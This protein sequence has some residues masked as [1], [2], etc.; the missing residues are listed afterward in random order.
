MFAVV[1]AQAASIRTRSPAAAEAALSVADLFCV[2]LPQVDA[3]ACK[4]VE[5]MRR[6]TGTP[7]A[8]RVAK[9][10]VAAALQR[11]SALRAK[12]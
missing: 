8:D 11:L 1:L 10:S 12:Q 7:D 9:E 5:A 2:K 4:A 6:S 3:A